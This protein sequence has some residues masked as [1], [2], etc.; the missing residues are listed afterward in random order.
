MGGWD[1]LLVTCSLC[2]LL[3]ADS[4]SVYLIMETKSPTAAH[5]HLWTRQCCTS[6]AWLSNLHRDLLR[7][8]CH[9]L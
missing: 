2:S 6:R 4:A 8:L 3:I 1:V 5:K 7:D 9:A